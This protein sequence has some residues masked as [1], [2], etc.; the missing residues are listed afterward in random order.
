MADKFLMRCGL[1][2]FGLAARRR[3]ISPCGTGCVG[4]TDRAV[5]R[6]QWQGRYGTES[7]RQGVR[8]GHVI[9]VCP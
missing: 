4:Q 1:L 7:G 5:A 9:C 2:A 8:N 6:D 3:G